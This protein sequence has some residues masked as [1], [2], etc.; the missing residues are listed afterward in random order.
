MVVTVVK[1]C[2]FFLPNQPRLEAEGT[3]VELCMW[4]GLVLEP[5]SQDS[6][7]VSISPFVSPGL[8]GFREVPQVNL[9]RGLGDSGL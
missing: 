2:L 4:A 5:V 7:E 1:P 3:P 8:G 6:L 9:L